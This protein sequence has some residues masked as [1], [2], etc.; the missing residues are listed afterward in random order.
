MKNG[1]TRE[2]FSMA[3]V[4]LLK[5][6][7]IESVTV[8]EMNIDGAFMEIERNQ[9]TPIVPDPE[10]ENPVRNLKEKL[11]ISCDYM[12]MRTI[13][14]APDFKATKAQKEA[15]EKA[16]D[17]LKQKTSVTGVHVSG[18]DQNEGVIITGKIQAANG[19]NIAINSPR[20]RFTSE[21]F[22]FEEELEGEIAVIE[23]ELFLYLHE[24]KKG[25]LEVFSE[26]EQ[27]RKPDELPLQEH[28]AEDLEEKPKAKK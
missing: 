2:N 23:R 14:N 7:G 6:G 19:S 10:L 25:Q 28:K 22:G 3:K 9:K 5:G 11:L 8:L 4:K 15:V 1:I 26:E 24:G 12:I 16:I 18:Q 27:G 21:V 13:V 20:M 17:I